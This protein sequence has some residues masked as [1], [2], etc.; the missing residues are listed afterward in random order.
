M[1]TGDFSDFFFLKTLNAAGVVIRLSVPSSLLSTRLVF[2]VSGSPG[3]PPLSG[4]NVALGLRN[5][6]RKQKNDFL[7][8][9]ARRV[10]TVSECQRLHAA[11]LSSCITD[12]RSGY[13]LWLQAP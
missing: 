13:R 5:K 3:R 8:F 1:S 11:A 6:L 4:R 12:H 7:I 9:K 10:D 2:L